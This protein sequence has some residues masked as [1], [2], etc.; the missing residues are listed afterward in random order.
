MTITTNQ[1][2]PLV[3]LPELVEADRRVAKYDGREPLSEEKLRRAVL[4][5]KENA[6]GLRAR[7]VPIE[8]PAGDA[9][10]PYEQRRLAGRW[11]RIADN[12]LLGRE[13]AA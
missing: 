12:G 3:I 1:R 7:G 10:D 5:A 4:R 9:D 8:E 11:N 2:P 6:D 13:Q